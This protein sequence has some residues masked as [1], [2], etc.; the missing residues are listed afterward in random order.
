MRQFVRTMCINRLPGSP[1]LLENSSSWP[2]GLGLVTFIFA[3]IYGLFHYYSP[4]LVRC[5]D[6]LPH[7]YITY[8]IGKDAPPKLTAYTELM[9][10]HL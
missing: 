4:F 1:K 3:G 10:P 9:Q 6:V 2:L 5:T 7:T 8:R